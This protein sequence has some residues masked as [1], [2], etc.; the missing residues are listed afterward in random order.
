M[1][2]DFMLTFLKQAAVCR[3]QLWLNVSYVQL[4]LR[5]FPPAPMR[6]VKVLSACERFRFLAVAARLGKRRG[7][8]RRFCRGESRRGRF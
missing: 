5:L 2:T 6:L 7:A 3:K 1:G 4:E 8:G